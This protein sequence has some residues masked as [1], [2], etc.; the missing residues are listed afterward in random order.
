MGKSMRLREG[1]VI[2]GGEGRVRDSTIR[3]WCTR[4]AVRNL[5]STA[6]VQRV[7]QLLCST[8]SV[9]S[10]LSALCPHPPPYPYPP[11]P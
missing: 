6:L 8:L 11:P 7:A 2:V 10:V 1:G 3:W 4:G 5:D 9:L